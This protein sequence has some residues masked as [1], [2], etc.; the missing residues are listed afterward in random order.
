MTRPVARIWIARGLE[1]EPFARAT[2]RPET[3]G[4][5][6]VEPGEP[7]EIFVTRLIQAVGTVVV[8]EDAG[9]PDVGEKAVASQTPTLETATLEELSTASEPDR[10][11]YRASSRSRWRRRTR[12]RRLRDPEVLLEPDAAFGPGSR[13]PCRWASSTRR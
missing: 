7:T 6:E 1:E 9:A 11:L 12:S 3:I 13:A 4:V 5:G 2:A 8:K 10:A